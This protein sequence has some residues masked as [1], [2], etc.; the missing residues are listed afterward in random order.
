MKAK[1][2]TSQQSIR[3]NNNTIG[4]RCL[5]N[6]LNILFWNALGLIYLVFFNPFL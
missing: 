6:Q 5:Q 3:N 2:K 4:K 1:K